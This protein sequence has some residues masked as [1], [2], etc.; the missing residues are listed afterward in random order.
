MMDISWDREQ[1][2]GDSKPER[3]LSLRPPDRS[4]GGREFADNPD[5]LSTLGRSRSIRAPGGCIRRA[6]AV[7]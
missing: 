5:V 7:T 2:I 4:E 3:P 6:G 1:G